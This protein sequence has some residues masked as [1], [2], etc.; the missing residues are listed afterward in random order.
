MAVS[1]FDFTRAQFSHR[2]LH[3]FHEIIYFLAGFKPT[4]VT[5]NLSEITCFNQQAMEACNELMGH[6]TLY[7]EYTWWRRSVHYCDHMK[8]EDYVVRFLA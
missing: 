5:G 3:D 4:E 7:K 1:H 8:G 6:K 2:K